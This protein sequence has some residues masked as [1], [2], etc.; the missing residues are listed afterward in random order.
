[1]DNLIEKRIEIL[2]KSLEKN[3]LDTF[4]VL[5]EQNRYY[6]SGYTGEDTQFDET[7][8]A[9]FI[10]P[11]QLVLATDSRFDLQAKHEAPLYEVITYKKGLEKEIPSIA[12][13]L[14]TKRLGFESLRLTFLQYRKIRKELDEQN[15]SEITLIDTEN[16]VEELRIVKEEFEI[17]ALKDA[18]KI[19]ENVFYEFHSPFKTRHD[20]KRYFLAN[21]KTNA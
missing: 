18:L 20:R 16:I 13:K 12:Q 14:N 19:A 10:T 9:L 3:N 17:A 4:M 5:V 2:R 11:D 8:G 6:L 21:G 1:V 7:A 15:L